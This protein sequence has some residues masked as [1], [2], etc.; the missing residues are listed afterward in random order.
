MKSKIFALFF[1]S[2]LGFSCAEE[3]VIPRTNPRFTVALVQLVDATGAEFSA[4]I[5]DFGSEEIEEYG[6]AY[7][8]NVNPTILNADYVSE[9]GKPEREFKLKASHSMKVGDIIFV[10]AFLKTTKGTIYSKPYSFTS[11]GSDGFIFDRIEIPSEVYFGDTLKVFASNL[12]KVGNKYA[13]KIQGVIAP[14]GQ[15]KEDYFEVIIPR[16]IGFLQDQGMEQMF[17]VEFDVAGKT[18][19]VEKAFNFKKPQI[20]I[21]P[22]QPLGY[23]EDLL[24][25]G[26]Y[27]EDR[28]L[29]V[30]YKNQNGE[31]FI[32][33]VDGNG[34]QEIRVGLNALFTEREPQL[35]LII[36]GN[37]YTVDKL[38]SLKET[39]ILPGQETTFNGSSGFFILKGENFNPKSVDF[40]KIEFS[41]DI[42]R[43]QVNSLTSEEMEISF[44]YVGEKP[45]KRE[46]SLTLNNAGQ[47]TKDSFSI[48]WTAPG[49]PVIPFDESYYGISG[50]AV[51]VGNKGYLISSNGVFEIDPIAQTVKLSAQ[52][53]FPV[54]DP[55][56]LFAIEGEGKI[57]FAAYSSYNPTDPKLFYSFD[58]VAKKVTQLPSIPSE[59]HSF[60]SVVIVDGQLYYQGDKIIPETGYDG[61]IQRY[62]FDFKSKEWKK[63]PSLSQHDGVYNFYT[64]F[65]WNG[66]LYAST[67]VAFDETTRYGMGIYKF[68]KAKLEWELFR[69]L[70]NQM[71]FSKANQTV[72]IGNRVYF[73]SE[74]IWT[75]LDLDTWQA[76]SPDYL[77]SR[78]GFAD[79]KTA[80]QVGNVFYLWGFN[81]IFE[82]DPKYFY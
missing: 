79:A 32:L 57:Y 23:T 2:L 11:Q 51:A 3:E 71:F 73:K 75:V 5:L 13:A 50:R 52:F 58:P 17:E 29:Q 4:S 53:P 19:K 81:S 44:E 20:E 46:I 80:F 56:S 60:Q 35:E 55:T 8:T 65:E 69:F 59:D 16:G 67:Y 30:K 1:I 39:V 14:I 33:D 41:P 7:G 72:Q 25:K 76:E 9:T 64:S 45:A 21:M 42:F 12:S 48:T 54:N 15:I 6:F 70:E 18:L 68:N 31:T 49:I 74:Y 43:Y 27:L 78:Y 40:N 62:L 47:Q 10:S 37:S 24:I 34:D 63:L 66:E 38:L 22:S 77:N 61:D 36:R 82:F 26:E 28:Y